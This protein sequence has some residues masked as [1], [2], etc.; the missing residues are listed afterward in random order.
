MGTVAGGWMVDHLT[1]LSGTLAAFATDLGPTRLNDMTLVTLTEFGRRGP[2]N[3]SGGTDHGFG[4][5][6]LLLGGGVRGG[7]VHLNGRWP[8]LAD[9]DL[10]DGDLNGTTDYR[11][12][13]AEILEKRCRLGTATDVFPGLDSTRINC[14][15]VKP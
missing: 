13:L 14:V 11:W 6:V 5:A 15:N 10:V 4:Q 7:Q 8:G 1:E 2:E 9:P 3:G 12:V